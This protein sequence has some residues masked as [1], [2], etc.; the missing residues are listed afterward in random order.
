VSL[1]QELTEDAYLHVKVESFQLIPSSKGRFEVSLDGELIYSK[2]AT[3]R[4]GEV[5]EIYSLI[6]ARMK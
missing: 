4:H 2:A 6:K 5:G 1:L 3:G